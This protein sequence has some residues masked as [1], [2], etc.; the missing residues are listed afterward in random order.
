MQFALAQQASVGSIV[1]IETHKDEQTHPWVI[2][3]VAQA[4]QHSPI[5]S[6][7]HDPSRDAVHWE[8]VRGNEVALQV[9]VFE[10]LQLGSTIYSKCNL[11]VWVPARQV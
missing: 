4:M 8:P 7:P 5:A 6:S 9:H 2:G 3:E 1:C 11:I 10:P